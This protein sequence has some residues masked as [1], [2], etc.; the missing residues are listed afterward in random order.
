MTVGG[1]TNNPLGSGKQNAPPLFYA[2]RMDQ[3]TAST[4]H[5][6]RSLGRIWHRLIVTPWLQER[7]GAGFDSLALHKNN[8]GVRRLHNFPRTSADIPHKYGFDL[9]PYAGV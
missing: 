4:S 8:S 9:A 7:S 2:D 1:D 3:K 5:V 6:W